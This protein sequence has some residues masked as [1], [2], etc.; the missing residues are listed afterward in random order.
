MLFVYASRQIFEGNPLFY[1]KLPQHYVALRVKSFTGQHMLT[2]Y[3]VI[4][5]NAVQHALRIF[6]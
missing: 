2:V 1:R 6:L 5:I 3:C 4:N